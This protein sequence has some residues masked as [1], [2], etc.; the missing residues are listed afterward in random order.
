MSDSF[1]TFTINDNGVRGKGDYTI[2]NDVAKIAL[3]LVIGAASDNP[4]DGRTAVITSLLP[5]NRPNESP[6][7]NE[8]SSSSLL[9]N[10][11]PIASLPA[12]RGPS[13][14]LPANNGPS[15]SLPPNGDASTSFPSNNRPTTQLP[16]KGEAANLARVI[17]TAEGEFKLLKLS[18]KFLFT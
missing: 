8:G 7:P 1:G 10:N 12:N 17:L 5:K 14:S 3:E 16:P 13:E 6:S 4:D 18:Y 11:G 15:T 9:E 2:V